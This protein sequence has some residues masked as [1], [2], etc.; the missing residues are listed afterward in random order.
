M[1]HIV[2][3]RFEYKSWLT[4]VNI[5]ENCGREFINLYDSMGYDF[6]GL[7]WIR[8]LRIWSPIYKAF[9][10]LLLFYLDGW[11]RDLM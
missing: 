9:R 5:E 1:F 6:V 3:F 4:N 2:S 8:I 7:N 11:L 10:C